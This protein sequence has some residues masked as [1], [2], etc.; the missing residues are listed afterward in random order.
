MF[1][2]IINTDMVSAPICSTS[3]TSPGCCEDKNLK[4][5]SNGASE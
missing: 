1:V 2:T 3:L 5:E 4:S